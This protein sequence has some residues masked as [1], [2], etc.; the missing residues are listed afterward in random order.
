[1]IRIVNTSQKDQTKDLNTTKL[2]G[3]SKP[4]GVNTNRFV[5]DE[6][7]VPGAGSYKLPD[8]CTVKQ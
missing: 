3:D 7:G 2:G 4:F 5:G 6:N 8:S 1:M